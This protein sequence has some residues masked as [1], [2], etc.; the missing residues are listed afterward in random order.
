LK[1]TKLDPYEAIIT[2]GNVR[3]LRPT[4]YDLLVFTALPYFSSDERNIKKPA[5]AF[6][7]NTAS[8]FDPA[9]DF[10]HR[11]FETKDSTSLE[12]YA[13]QLYQQVIAF[14]INDPQ[15]TR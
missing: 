6:E 2:K 14:H 15:P 12:F 10:I 11:K 4:L 13:L 8:A 9:A 7:I 5:Y 1:Q 3:K